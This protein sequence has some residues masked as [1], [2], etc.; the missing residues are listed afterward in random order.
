MSIGYAKLTLA[1]DNTD[2]IASGAAVAVYGVHVTASDGDMQY[3]DGV[4][5]YDAGNNVVA[6]HRAGDA[7]KDNFFKKG[8]TFKNG[9][10]IEGSAGTAVTVI[11][12]KI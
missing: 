5:E 2:T 1:G 9:L 6:F 7:L 11:Y 12:E 3:Y 4:T 8:I 10:Y